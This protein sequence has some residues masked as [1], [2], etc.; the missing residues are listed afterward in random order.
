MSRLAPAT[1]QTLSAFGQG[2]SAWRA[3]PAPVLGVLAN[4]IRKGLLILWARPASIILAIVTTSFFYLGVQFIIGQGQLPRDLLPPTLV[5]FSAYMF[6]YFASLAMVA[7]LVEEM[8]TGTLGQTF[9]SPAPSWLLVLGRLGT[10]SVQG[11]LVAAFAV[12]VPMIAVGSPIPARPEAV[13]PLALA[14]IHGLAF[15]LLFAGIALTEPFIGEIHHLVVGLVGMLNG[16]YLPVALFPDW[17]EP[18]ARLLPTT[19]GIEATLRVLFE[20]RSLG[21]LWADGSLPWLLGYTLA[22]TALGWLVFTRNQ[23]KALRDGTLG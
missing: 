17:L 9:L 18:I 5:A 15:T 23:R 1:E 2:S 16:A 14:F 10:A 19:L 8:R 20:R 6:L 3:R 4:E 7:D 12:V 22:L 21:D 13:V 11:I